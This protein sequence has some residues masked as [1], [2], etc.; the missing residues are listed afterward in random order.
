[1][2][3]SMLR[4]DEI[5]IKNTDFT[6]L[7]FLSK[8]LEIRSPIIFSITDISHP[9]INWLPYQTSGLLNQAFVFARHLGKK[10]N[11]LQ[12]PRQKIV[13]SKNYYTL[14]ISEEPN[15]YILE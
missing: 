3:Y 11:F 7:P 1:M 12:Q 14:E 5:K 4:M 6:L 15:F 8:Q 2:K 13:R 9:H 10:C